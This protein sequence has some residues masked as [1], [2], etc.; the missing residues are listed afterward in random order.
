MEF[1]FPDAAVKRL[2]ERPASVPQKDSSM[3]VPLRSFL[4]FLKQPFFKK[5]FRAYRDFTE[6]KNVS[7]YKNDSEYKKVFEYKNVS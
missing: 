5:K 7:E 6:Y 2:S 1:L 4:T 3:A